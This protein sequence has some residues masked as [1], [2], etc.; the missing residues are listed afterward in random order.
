MTYTPRPEHPNPQWER[1]NWT[2]LNGTWAFEIDKSCTGE[3]RGLV[4]A[5]TLSGSITVPFCP[6]CKLSGVEDKDFLNCV[7]YKKTISLTQEQLQGNRVLFHIGACDYETKIWVNGQSTGFS[8]KGG[9]TP[10]DADITPFLVAGLVFGLA[11]VLGGANYGQLISYILLII[12][13]AVRPQGL[14]SK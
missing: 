5:P 11:Q 4:E 7:W 3:F 8:H 2:N 10:I 12:M 9:Y 14:F 1:S 13:L 6:E